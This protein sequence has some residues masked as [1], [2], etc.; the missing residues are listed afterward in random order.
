MPCDRLDLEDG[1]SAWICTSGRARP[2]PCSSCGAPAHYQCDFPLAGKR[3]GATC[4]RFLCERCRRPQG[5]RPI[6]NDPTVFAQAGVLPEHAARVAAK[7]PR[8]LETIDYCP[9][10]HELAAG[11][12]TPLHVGEARPVSPPPASGAQRT[13]FGEEDR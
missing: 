5:T 10:H 11:K 12:V 3:A 1:T 6:P 2:K 13:L 8:A 9:A 7:S 4:D